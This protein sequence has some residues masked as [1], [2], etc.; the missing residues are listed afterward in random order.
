VSRI[1]F[2][3]ALAGVCALWSCADREPGEQGQESGAGEAEPAPPPRRNL[4]LISIDTLRAD[5][6][7][8]YGY[9]RDTSPT[10]DGLAARGVRFETVIAESCW[11]LPS[12]VTLFTGLPPSFHGV[13]KPHHKLPQ[14]LTTLAE[15]LQQRGYHTFGVTGGVFLRP[16]FAIAQGFERYHLRP[17]EFPAALSLA[18]RV[19]AKLGPGEPF[20]WFIHTYDV[21]CPYDPP[22]QYAKM[23]DSRPPEDQLDTR[24]RCGNPHYNRM[25]LTPGQARFLSD[26]YDASIRYADDLLKRFLE[27]LETAGR[28]ENT[29][30]VIVSDHGEEFLEHGRIGHRATLFMESLR[31]P[32]ILVGPGIEPRVVTQPVGLADVMPTLLDLL[33]IPSPPMKGVSL[34]PLIEGKAQ[35]LPSSA[36]FSENQWGA[37]LYSGVFG[38][39]HLIARRKPPRK[40]DRGADE[41]GEIP[42]RAG[43]SPEEVSYQLYDWRADQLEAN[44]L[45]GA[46]PDRDRELRFA[47]DQQMKR[48]DHA[49]SRN[50]PQAVPKPSDEELERLH[51]LGYVDVE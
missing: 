28:L 26:R 43:G 35:G 25:S 50:Q 19:L 36:V 47:L 48:L 33:E 27:K 21:H 40:T 12:H 11:T 41:T 18:L 31:V 38:D 49:R 44:D 45:L 3:L 29:L 14:R 51:A 15:V 1:V 8:A 39:Y 2:A 4:I 16:S 13:T 5:H 42:E 22:P 34:R 17:L 37:K 24:E 32:W 6:L 9:P 23:F 46:V 7:G 10:L 20:F 30:I